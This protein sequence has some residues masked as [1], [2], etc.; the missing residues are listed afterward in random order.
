M[1]RGFTLE[2]SYISFCR[3]FSVS[4]TAVESLLQFTPSTYFVCLWQRLNSVAWWPGT[5]FVA[6]QQPS[7]LSLMSAGLTCV[8]HHAGFWYLLVERPWLSFCKGWVGYCGGKHL[9]CLFQRRGK[10]RCVKETVSLLRLAAAA[11][12]RLGH[13]CS[14]RQVLSWLA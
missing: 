12:F 14:R 13:G 7:C 8:S 4:L 3:F 11:F 2:A 10:E 9:V 1:G 5:H 6:Q